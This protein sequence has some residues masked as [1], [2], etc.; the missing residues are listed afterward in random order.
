M[1]STSFPLRLIFLSLL[2][3]AAMASCS[4]DD[5]AGQKTDVVTDT[6]AVAVPDPV[7]SP[8][9][10]RDRITVAPDTSVNAEALSFTLLLTHE[11]LGDQSLR[12]TVKHWLVG[13]TL[14]YNFQ[15]FGPMAAPAVEREATLE[16]AQIAEL[17]ALL[18]DHEL[19]ANVNEAFERDPKINSGVQLTVNVGETASLFVV[20]GART[21]VERADSYQR[22]LKLSRKV[23]SL[24]GI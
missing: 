22:A 23:K 7:T 9:S 19:T 11:E 6:S 5:E 16:S 10:A 3:L 2:G 1:Y 13:H 21:A 15:E 4:T 12:R 20:Q 24:L 8:V 18:K 14:R 17:S